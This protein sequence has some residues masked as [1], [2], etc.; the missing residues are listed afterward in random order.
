MNLITKINISIETDPNDNYNLI[1]KHITQ[2]VDKYLPVKIV[3]YNRHLQTYNRILKQNIRNAK[4]LY[5]H[6]CFDKF[7]SDIKKKWSTIKDILN[8]NQND[9]CFPNYFIING[10]PVSDQTTIA[11][12]FNKYFTNIGP[13]LASQINYPVGKSSKDYLLTPT[14]HNF[15]FGKVNSDSIKEIINKLKNKSTS[16]WDKLSNK[17]LKLIKDDIAEPLTV[18]INQTFS[19][20]VFPH[21]LKIAKVIPVHKN[22][23]SHTFNNYRPISILPSVSKVFERVMHNQLHKYFSQLKLYYISKIATKMDN[24][25]VPINIH[26]DLSKAFDT[27]DHEILLYKL[28]YYGIR[29][30]SLKLFESYLHNITQYTEIANTTSE[31]LLITTGVPQ[32]SILGPLLFLI[33]INDISLVSNLFYPIVYADD[34]TL[35]ATLGTFGT[36]P[37]QEN[38]INEVLNKVSNWLKFNKLSLNINKTKAMV[39]HTHQRIV[40]PPVIRIENTNVEY[41]S[42]F[43]FLGIIIDKHLSWKSHINHII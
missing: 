41:L 16:G 34:T 31:P 23:D 22:G 10:T 30:S 11:N 13:S 37:M 7:K 20:G 15:S 21:K 25:E 27:L 9:K 28:N 33:Y 4:K 26:L 38:N 8:K 36:G 24:D 42:E 35:S 18:I 43:N 19:S 40:Q 12:E 1:D 6:Q 3:R 39:F 17:L 5:Y 2:S 32:G 14:P 29:N